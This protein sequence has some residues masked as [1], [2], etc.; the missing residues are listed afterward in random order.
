MNSSQHA[1]TRCMGRLK[2]CSRWWLVHIS[3]TDVLSQPNISPVK[4]GFCRRGATADT[5]L[6]F[7]HKW[8][9][10]HDLCTVLLLFYYHFRV[11]YVLPF[12]V[13][14]SRTTNMYSIILFTAMG[15]QLHYIASSSRIFTNFTVTDCFKFLVMC[16][17][18][19]SPE[20]PNSWNFPWDITHASVSFAHLSS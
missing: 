19:T 2:T 8:S 20:V 12:Q 6:L 3:L 7:E 9:R 4:Q 13:V 11:R 10:Y 14:T 15:G 17:S 1:V 16:V 18:M 5:Y